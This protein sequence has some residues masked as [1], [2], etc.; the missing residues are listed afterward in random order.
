V[1]PSH[2]RSRE[3]RAPVIPIV[4]AV[5]CHRHDEMRRRRRVGSSSWSSMAPSPSV[6]PPLT[7]APASLIPLVLICPFCCPSRFYRP[8]C[9]RRM[10]TGKRRKE[11]VEL[12]PGRPREAPVQRRRALRIRHLGRGGVVVDGRCR[13]GR[14]GGGG[15]RRLRGATPPPLPSGRLVPL[16]GPR[17]WNRPCDL[18]SSWRRRR[19]VVARPP[20]T[21][22]SA[23]AAR[24]QT[25]DDREPRPCPGF[26]NATDDNDDDGGG[27]DAGVDRD[28]RSSTT[29][30]SR[31]WVPSGEGEGE[32]DR[33]P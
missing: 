20:T 32:R 11:R 8:S 13:E 25:R 33:S 10:T 26:W 21:T 16:P 6:S 5:G 2:R 27:G 7:S 17:R 4:R 1:P 31:D 3:A 29:S 18:S 22:N 15:G 30:S 19:I 12:P 24:W 9:R 28:P 14:G 23:A